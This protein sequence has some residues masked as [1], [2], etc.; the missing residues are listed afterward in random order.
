MDFDF[1]FDLHNEQ[2]VYKRANKVRFA[3]CNLKES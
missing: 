3:I 1:F 2:Y